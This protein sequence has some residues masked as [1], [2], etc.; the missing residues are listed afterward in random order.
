MLI[1]VDEV[2]FARLRGIASDY[3][4]RDWLR[5]SKANLQR[6]IAASHRRIVEAEAARQ[7]HAR[8]VRRRE[9]GHD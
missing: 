7:S 4:V 2:T 9:A 3:G 6:D 1:R 8:A 5:K